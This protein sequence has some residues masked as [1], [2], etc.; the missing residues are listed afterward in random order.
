MQDF[1]FH[2]PAAVADA[3]GLLGSCEDPKLIA[4]GMTLLPTLKQRLA[5]P[6]DLIDLGAIADLKGIR[7]EGEH[8]VVG[9]MTCHADVAASELVL[10]TIPGLAMLAG[11]IGDPAV[12]HRGTIGGSCANADP[13][14]DYPAGIVGLGATVVT[15]Q[16]EI[17]GDD[18]FVGLF[19]TALEPGE[20]ITAMRFPVPKW[21]HYMKLRH[22]ASGYAVVGVMIVDTG[23]GVRV[24]V[25]GAGPSAFRVTAMEEA[26]SADFSAK[27]I[28]AIKV[29]ADGLNADMHASAAYRAH[30]IGVLA[31]RAIAARR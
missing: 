10:S 20:I 18:F 25:T 14:A 6:T 11:Q 5:E 22:P 24:A 8:I 16:R 2:M 23:A 31:K 28:D 21:S 7:R 3:S 9:A 29:D 12:R 13:A 15:N 1:T 27:A 19:E 26:L 4:G 30:V 17:A